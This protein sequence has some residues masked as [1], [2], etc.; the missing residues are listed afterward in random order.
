VSAE[1]ATVWLL[2]ITGEPVPKPNA[3]DEVAVIVRNG[4]PVPSTAYL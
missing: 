4:F 1:P 3:P 2:V